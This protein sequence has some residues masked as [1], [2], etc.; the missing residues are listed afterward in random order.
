MQ[1]IITYKVGKNKRE[2]VIEAVDLDD[3]ERTAERRF[4]K[5]VDIIYRNQN[6]EMVLNDGY[7]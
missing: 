4:P 1:F 5:W 6:K 3:A 2:K 7:W